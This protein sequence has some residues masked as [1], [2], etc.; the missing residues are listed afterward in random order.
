MDHRRD[1]LK[2][3]DILYKVAQNIESKYPDKCKVI[4]TE[5][6]PYNKYIEQMKGCDILLDQIYSYTPAMN[7]LQAMSMGLVT[8]SGG[9]EEHY[10]L[11]KEEDLR[12]IV[13]VQPTEKDIYNKLEWLIL[14]PEE[15]AQLKLDGKEYI[16]LH[17]DSIKI[18]Q[19]YIE[20]WNK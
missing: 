1:E 2:G 4:A 3:T 19:Q 9:E 8:V 17:H 12:P 7:A 10:K 20:C 15:I 14:H 16:R 6:L 5:S 13:N 18:A 11:I